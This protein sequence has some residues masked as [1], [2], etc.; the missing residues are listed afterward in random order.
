LLAFLGG[1]GLSAPVR[2]AETLGQRAHNQ[3]SSKPGRT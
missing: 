2:A 1:F 3:S